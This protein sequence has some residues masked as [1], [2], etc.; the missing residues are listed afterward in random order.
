MP[1]MDNAK[2]IFKEAKEHAAVDIQDIR[3]LSKVS[4]WRGFFAVLSEWLIISAAVWFSLRF[5]NVP[6]YL[7]AWLIIGTRMYALYSLLHDGIH[8]LLFPNK[9]VNDWICKRF[10]SWPLF[11][12]FSRI[13]KFHLAHHQ[14]LKTPDDPE[15]VHLQYK[16]F[17]FPL[18]AT[19]VA[20]TFL[21]DITGINFVF[22]KSSKILRSLSSGFT[23]QGNAKE[24]LSGALA[25]F[26]WDMA[27]FYVVL[28]AY[29]I[30]WH[31]VWPFVLYW[32]IP[33]ITIYQVLNRIRLS[34]EHFHLPEEKLFQTRTV[35]LNLFER[36][37]FSP[38]NL[39][40]HTEHHLY[41]SVPFYRLP[42]LHKKLMNAASY[43]DNIVVSKSYFQVIKEYVK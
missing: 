36:F 30:Y 37:V 19:G 39:G 33:Y 23:R 20:F 7:V 9:Q 21:K 43:R 25:Q 31:L 13:R 35:K 10:L 8:Y 5:N 24:K 3:M 40:Y 28:V 12:S 11:I 18:S 15:A 42:A 26:D 27:I 22:Y 34:T 16:E 29:L 2:T 4:Y 17:Q 1:F 41:P 14:Y 6:A 32:I 38:H